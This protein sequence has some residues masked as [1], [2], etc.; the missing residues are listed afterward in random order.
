MS[1]SSTIQVRE[2]SS[3]SKN[4]MCIFIYSILKEIFSDNEG[5]LFV[6]ELLDDR[7]S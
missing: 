1:S 4:K 5:F 6:I 7:V 2:I 3:S